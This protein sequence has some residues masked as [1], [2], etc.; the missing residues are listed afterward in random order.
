[1]AGKPFRSH[2]YRLEDP[3][4]ADKVIEEN[5][6]VLAK[7]GYALLAGPV[8]NHEPNGGLY[9]TMVFRREELKR[10]IKLPG[11]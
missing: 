4:S 9:V 5:L 1:M 8:F 10:F 2:T 6:S 11:R 7:D 3:L